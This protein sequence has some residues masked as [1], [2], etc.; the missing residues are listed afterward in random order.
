MMRSVL[1]RYSK[2]RLR[3]IVRRTHKCAHD[4]GRYLVLNCDDVREVFLADEVKC[5]GR[6]AGIDVAPPKR[7]KSVGVVVSGISVI[8][9]P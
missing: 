2:D 6:T 5:D 8:T 3:I 7:C 1:P 9:N 4:L